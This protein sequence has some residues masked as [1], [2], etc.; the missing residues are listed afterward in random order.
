MHCMETVSMSSKSYAISLE[1]RQ[2]CQILPFDETQEKRFSPV[3][4][5]LFSYMYEVQSIDFS[6]YFRCGDQIIEFIKPEE[7]SHELLQK[8]LVSTNKDFDDIYI[9]V[10]KK[11]YPLFLNLLGN[12]RAKKI[13]SLME[14]DPTLDRKTLDLFANLSGASQMVVKGGIDK[15]VAFQAE[16]SAMHL[17]DNLMD[18]EIVIGTLSRMVIADPTLYDHSAAVAMIAGV[19]SR[20]LLS[21]DRR[22]SQRIALGGLYHDVGKTCVPNQILNK[23]GKF[24]PE[25]FEVMKTHTSL[26]YEELL[27]AIGRGAP[28][29]AEVAL[30]A[31]QHHEKFCGHGYPNG[32]KGRLEEDSKGIHEFSRI[33]SIADVYSA[34][35]MKRV[36][37]E[38]F[39]PEKAMTIMRNNAPTDYDPIIFEPFIDS[40]ESSTKLYQTLEKKAEKDKGKI[41]V[42]DK[43]E[44]AS[45]Y[46]RKSS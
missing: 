19:I 4:L 17:V 37:K 33:V 1:T 30:V 35:L 45:K 5:E 29:D 44:K 20:K 21:K 13:V 6:L 10:L 42:V 12:V 34:L 28:I 15:N 39:P 38:P 31:L 14:R 18:S 36:Y 7:F 8:L 46:L 26:G 23:P 41:I 2:R 16:Q 3:S 27:Q 24:T 11:E 40:V 43:N 9:C 22:S 32:L 25:E